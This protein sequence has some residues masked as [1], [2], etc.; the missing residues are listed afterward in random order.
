MSQLKNPLE[1]YKLLPKSNCGQ[2]SIRTCM[3]FA[4]AVLMGE[5]QLSDCPHISTGDPGLKSAEI[6]THKSIARNREKVV[7]GLRKKVSGMDLLSS[8]ERLGASIVGDSLVI[9]CLGKDFF[10]DSKGNI[11]SDYHTHSW[12]TFI[13]LDYILHDAGDSLSGQWIP[14]RELKKGIGM[15]PLFEQ[16]CEKPLKRMADSNPDLFKDLIYIFSA[17]RTTNMFSSDI[18]LILYPLPKVP[19]LICYW[20]QDGDIESSLHVFF[21]ST[22]ENRLSID[23]IHALGTGLAVMFEKVVSKHKT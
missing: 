17:D 19:M 20:E 8:A 10:I 15:A 7:E 21:D 13:L 18:S 3:A 22:V 16:L 9:K 14:F 5:K 11:T 23:A 1:I 12:M 4:A 2:C 6:I